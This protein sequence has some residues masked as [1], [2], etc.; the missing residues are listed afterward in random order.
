MIN[1]RIEHL[2]DYFKS[3]N[4]IYFLSHTVNPKTDNIAVIKLYAENY[5]THDKWHFV[6]GNQNEIYNMATNSYLVKQLK[7]EDGI[8]FIHSPKL[9][10]IDK[11]R[12]IR[13][14]YDLTDYNYNPQKVIDDIERLLLE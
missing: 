8:A 7:N 9:I 1:N 5:K 3:S 14:Y 4:Q 10:L 2:V 13:A 6:T 12:L 11:D